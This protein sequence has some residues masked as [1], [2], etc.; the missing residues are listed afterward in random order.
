[1]GLQ[2]QLKHIT[3]LY[4]IKALKHLFIKP[5]YFIVTQSSQVYEANILSSDKETIP[6]IK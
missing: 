6:E 3:K 2:T 5:F 4:C 1:M